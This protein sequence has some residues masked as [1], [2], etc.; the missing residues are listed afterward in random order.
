[1]N[2]RKN[3]NSSDHTYPLASGGG[4][5]KLQTEI[6]PAS[7]HVILTFTGVLYLSITRLIMPVTTCVA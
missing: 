2:V 3:T 5:E 4:T 6:L 1:M 7:H